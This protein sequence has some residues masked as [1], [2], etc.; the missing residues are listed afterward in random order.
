LSPGKRNN[1]KNPILREEGEE[2]IGEKGEEEE[3]E[4]GEEIGEEEN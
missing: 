1:S 2:E 3:E 4:G